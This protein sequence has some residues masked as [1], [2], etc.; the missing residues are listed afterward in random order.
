MQFI[1]I[2][3]PFGEK[4]VG[5]FFQ[6]SQSSKAKTLDLPRL[7][8]GSGDKIM[9]YENHWFPFIRPAIK[10]LFVGGRVGLGG[11]RLTIAISGCFRK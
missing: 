2:N 6:A 3:P 8:P 9:V 5:Y 4:I 1:S 7:H 11:G 10:P